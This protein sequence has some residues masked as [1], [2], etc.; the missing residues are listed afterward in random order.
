MSHVRTSKAAL[1]VLSA[2][3]ARAS[4]ETNPPV[5]E[6]NPS[7]ETGAITKKRTLIKGNEKVSP[8]GKVMRLDEET[9]IPTKTYTRAESRNEINEKVV[10]IMGNLAWSFLLRSFLKTL[11]PL[12][13]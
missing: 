5:L 10:K 3:N 4:N 7:I 6:N 9:E 13:G 12:I 8:I 11:K 2:T 1:A